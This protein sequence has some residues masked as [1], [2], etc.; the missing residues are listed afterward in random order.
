MT[1]RRY[2]T[3]TS[4]LVTRLPYLDAMAFRP[5][6]L[7]RIE[8]NGWVEA[9]LH[10]A[11]FPTGFKGPHILVP[12]GI[13]RE[14]GRIRASYT[15]QSLVFQHSLQ[16]IA[17]PEAERRTAKL[18]TAV[19]NSSLSAWF[20]FHETA[21]LGTDRAKVHQTELLGVPF[22]LPRDLEQVEPAQAT[23]DEIVVLMVN[24]IERADD[25]FI[26]PIEPLLKRIDELVFRYFGLSGNEAAI[27]ED[28]LKYIVPA[29][30]P[31]L[32]DRPALWQPSEKPDR[33]RYASLLAA[34]SVDGS[35]TGLELRSNSPR[36]ASP[37]VLRIVLHAK[38]EASTAYDEAGADRAVASVLERIWNALPIS[39]PGNFQAIPDVR[40]SLDGDLELDKPRQMRHWLKSTALA[41]ADGI[42]ADLHKATVL[43]RN[44]SQVPHADRDPAEWLLLFRDVEHR[45]IDII[46]TI[47]FRCSAGLEIQPREDQITRSLV[48][49]LEEECERSEALGRTHCQLTPLEQQRAGDAWRKATTMARTSIGCRTAYVAFPNQRLHVRLDSGF[50]SL[51]GQYINE[52][53]MRDVCA[54]YA[55]ELPLGSMIGYVMTVTWPGCSAIGRSDYQ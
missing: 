29:M 37:A 21:N 22:P 43:Q 34:A 54:Q 1:I 24:T 14:N 50:N 47:W 28:T 51:T 25:L 3:T 23:I 27:V 7:P 45:I 8:N 2:S 48:F 5:V 40:V 12:Q 46:P 16:A 31:S 4:E 19:L 15:E 17:F 9:V 26:A 41:D 53:M 6:A 44:R 32:R 55:L 33:A 11:G 52:G 10:R 39:L 20:V 18:L 49:H 42:A 38:R 36:L 13:E 30:Q 35:E